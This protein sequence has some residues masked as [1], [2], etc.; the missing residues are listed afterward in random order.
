MG[1]PIKRLV[2]NDCR[3][4]DTGDIPTGRQSGPKVFV[5]NYVERSNLISPP[6]FRGRLTV[7]HAVRGMERDGGRSESHPVMGWIWVESQGSTLPNP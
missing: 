3:S 4:S 2:R 7:R 5:V 1:D 6:Q